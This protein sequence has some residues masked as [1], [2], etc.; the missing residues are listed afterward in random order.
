VHIHLPPAPTIR[1]SVALWGA[2]GTTIGV[3]VKIELGVIV[4]AVPP[5][6]PEP[7]GHPQINT[8]QSPL[9]R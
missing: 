6:V 3:A 5:V 1:V 4:T 9:P 2:G 7:V 8:R